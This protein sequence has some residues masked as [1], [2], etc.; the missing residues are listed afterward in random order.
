MGKANI[1]IDPLVEPQSL[2]HAEI[3]SAIMRTDTWTNKV[4]QTD[5]GMSA[6][7]E[8]CLIGK[9]MKSGKLKSGKKRIHLILLVN[10]WNGDIPYERDLFIKSLQEHEFDKHDKNLIHFVNSSISL[11]IQD[12]I[13]SSQYL[14]IRDPRKYICTN[15]G[16]L[17]TYI[18]YYSDPNFIELGSDDIGG[19]EGQNSKKAIREFCCVKVRFREGPNIYRE[20]ARG[21]TS[22]RLIPNSVQVDGRPCIKSWMQV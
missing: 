18:C 13:S 9:N 19:V 16:T 4:M 5:Y 17:S 22:T 11:H 14:N 12:A 1:T 21:K 3:W 10:D 15:R 7:P 2:K 20:L 6:N 8:P